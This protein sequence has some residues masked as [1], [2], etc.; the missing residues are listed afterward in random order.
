MIAG[1]EGCPRETIHVVTPCEGDVV[2]LIKLELLKR[3]DE[4]EISSC[5][6][7]RVPR[8]IELLLKIVR[9]FIR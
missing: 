8:R 4:T 3:A 6:T 1:E 9:V 5:L 7:T 2:F